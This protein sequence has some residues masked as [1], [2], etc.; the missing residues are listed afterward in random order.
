MPV[1][2]HDP[3]QDPDVAKF[4]ELIANDHYLR[5]LGD[6]ASSV[7]IYASEQARAKT[8]QDQESAAVQQVVQTLRPPIN[9]LNRS[10]HQ[11]ESELHK[12]WRES[13]D[14]LSELH[15]KGV[16]SDRE[17]LYLSKL[18]ADPTSFD[19]R[20]ASEAQAEFDQLQPGTTVVAYQ[21]DNQS[22]DLPNRLS[23]VT[24]LGSGEL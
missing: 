7:A 24:V 2:E 21:H 19:Y 8:L 15:L 17:Y 22:S 4:Q 13:H 6:V 11:Q 1:I 20:G 16:L 18:W 5:Y 12:S 9:E 23:E 14:K 3:G 10:L